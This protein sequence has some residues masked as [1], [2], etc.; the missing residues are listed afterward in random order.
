MKFLSKF[1]PHWQNEKQ[2]KQQKTGLSLLHTNNLLFICF[3]FHGQK[4]H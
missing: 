2:Q 1:L 3:I 4:T